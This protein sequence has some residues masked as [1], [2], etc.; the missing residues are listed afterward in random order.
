MKDSYAAAYMLGI[1]YDFG[2]G[3][4]ENP[5]EAVRWYQESANANNIEAQ[6]MLG[7][8]FEHGRG[9][10]KDRKAALSWYSKAYKTNFSFMDWWC[11]EHRQKIKNARK[12]F[13]NGRIVSLYSD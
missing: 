12:E 9:T 10:V 4:L 7:Y 2:K 5:Q 3:V 11:S 13:Q 1:C 8:R 6:K